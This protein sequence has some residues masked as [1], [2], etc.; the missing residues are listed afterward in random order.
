MCCQ[1]IPWYR[2]QSSHVRDNIRRPRE[3]RH[4]RHSV[5][6][7]PSFRL[8]FRRRASRYSYDVHCRRGERST[9]QAAEGTGNGL[10]GSAIGH[11]VQVKLLS[12]TIPGKKY[13]VSIIE[14]TQHWLCACGL[15]P[16]VCFVWRWRELWWCLQWLYLDCIDASLHYDACLCFLLNIAVIMRNRHNVL[17]DLSRE[18]D[19]GYKSLRGVSVAC[20]GIAAQMGAFKCK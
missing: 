17:E 16:H 4:G 19:K 6:L 13:N 11:S 10:R 2:F 12:D 9:V 8:G 14:L 20:A 18:R 1:C 5:R 7:R 15:V 3:E